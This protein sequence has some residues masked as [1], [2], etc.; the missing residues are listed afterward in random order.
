MTETA[1]LAGLPLARDILGHI[2]NIPITSPAAAQSVAARAAHVSAIAAVELA[3]AT[4]LAALVAVF[5]STLHMT[6]EQGLE[7][8]N[9]IRAM[10]G[11]PPFTHP[12][13]D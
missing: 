8:G 12:K 11:F 6:D 10:I 1:P 9:T 13:E 7:L 3:S 4:Q 2:A 5:D